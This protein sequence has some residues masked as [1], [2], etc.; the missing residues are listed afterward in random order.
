MTRRKSEGRTM[1]DAIET[2]SL[3]AAQAGDR[4][5]FGALTEP[6][7]RALLLHCYR[8]LGSLQDAEDLVQ[9]ALLRAWQR[10]SSFEGRGSLRSWL[11]AIAT[12]CCL[13]ALDRRR[14]LPTESHPPATPD[15]P[16]VLASVEEHWLTPFPDRLLV[17]VES[18]PEARYT[19]RE[20]V[21]LAFLTALQRLPPRQRAV[22]LLREVLAWHADE[23]AQLLGLSVPTVNGLLHRARATLARH[24]ASG[25]IG[26]DLPARGD[27]A[28]QRLLDRYVRV[29]EAADIPGFLALLTDEATLA[30][31]PSPA[32]Y[33]G[34]DDIAVFATRYIFGDEASPV[35]SGPVEGR[36]RL[37]P[38]WANGLPAFGVYTRAAAGE[39]YRA[40]GVSLVIPDNG[41]IAAIISFLDPALMP[42]FDLPMSDAA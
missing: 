7:R 13:N 36:W 35:I 37:R 33:R 38:T 28:T 16:G 19:L 29:W 21:T 4:E 42:Y 31:P 1:I 5:A 6:H 23:V 24:R 14:H 8:M 39:D 11:Y 2:A 20:S 30:M 12:N 10:L 25:A 17:G 26:S 9:E 27:A 32:W 40:L 15:A 22:L 3:D 41:Q 18:D 34:R